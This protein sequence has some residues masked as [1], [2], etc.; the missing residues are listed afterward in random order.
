MTDTFTGRP[1]SARL[2]DAFLAAL[3]ERIDLAEV[4]SDYV[5][6][7]PAG[8]AKLKGLCPVHSE[9]TPSFVISTDF[10]RYRCFG[11]GAEGDAVSL[12]TD[13]GGLTFREAVES[14]AGSVGLAMPEAGEQPDAPDPRGALRDILAR[15]QPLL[16]SWLL[17]SPGGAGARRFLAD[18]NFGAEHATLWGLGFN[19]GGGTLHRAFDDADQ[20]ALTDAGM[21]ARS[22][23]GRLYDVFHDRLVWPLRDAQGRIVGYAGR[24][25]NGTSRAKYLNTR[26]TELYTKHEVL[27]GL[28]LARRQMLQRKQVIL[29]EGIHRRNGHGRCRTG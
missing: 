23:R 9:N 7:K 16:H 19:P 5:D 20:Q 10:H 14:L 25:L 26:D 3:R 29:V 13:V 1:R 11:C 21:T 15:S 4:A 6:L 12:L 22:D 18:R 27:F 24:D 28:H 17:D 8:A 2:P